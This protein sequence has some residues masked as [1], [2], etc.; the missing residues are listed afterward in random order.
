MPAHPMKVALWDAINRYVIS[1][2][3]DPGKRVQGNTSRMKAVTAVESA[4]G[5]VVDAER[6]ELEDLVLDVLSGADILTDRRWMATAKRLT[7]DR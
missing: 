2:K 4:L 6:R 3:G 5:A 7:G 1:C